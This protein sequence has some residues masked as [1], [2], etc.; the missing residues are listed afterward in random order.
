[1]ISKG[2]TVKLVCDRA[3]IDR[4]DGRTVCVR[5]GAATDI[6]AAAADARQRNTLSCVI[7]NSQVPLEDIE[8]EDS[9]RNIPIALIVPAVGR[10]R[11]I[12]RKA[13]T[14]RSLNLRVFLP[15]DA[16]NLAGARQLASLGIPVC[17]TFDSTPDWDALA[18]LMTYALLGLVPHA[19]VDPFHTIAEVYRQTSR[20][21]DWGRVWFDDPARYLHLDA[22]GRVALSRRDLEAGKFITDV[23]FQL[24]SPDVTRAIRQGREAWRDRFAEDHFCARCPSWRLCRARFCEGK[25]EPDGCQAFFS[26]MAEVLDRRRNTSPKPAAKW[27]P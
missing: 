20:G 10:F 2:R 8:I 14:L 21:E 19:P 16:R 25:A 6:A 23:P 3:L 12:A 1:M 9:W 11:N 4:L 13:A 18:D 22:A 24:D 7:C 27:Q 5:V 15:S 17:L 26:E